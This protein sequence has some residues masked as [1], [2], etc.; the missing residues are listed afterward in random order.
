MRALEATGKI[1]A[2]GKLSLDVPLKV[3]QASSVRVIIL[4][5]EP[6][7]G[8]EPH[9]DEVLALYRQYYERDL[10][11]DEEFCSGFQEALV[12]AGYDSREKI[13]QLV[14][15]VKQEMAIERDKEK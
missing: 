9:P 5:S 6:D 4:L 2:Q 14:Q 12:E 7:E 8:S 13:I 15:E 10:M 1:D 11:P 3:T